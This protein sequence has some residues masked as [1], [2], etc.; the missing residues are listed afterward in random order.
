MF[1]KNV[2]LTLTLSYETLFLNV[3]NVFVFLCFFGY[4]NVKGTFRF[5]ILQTL[6][7]AVIFDLLNILKQVVT[8]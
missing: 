2:W 5:I 1:S 4:T 7:G 6:C 3:P 8:F